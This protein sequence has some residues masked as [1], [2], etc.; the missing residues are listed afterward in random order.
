MVQVAR[1][2]SRE[3]A[4]FAARLARL[5]EGSD[6]NLSVIWRGRTVALCYAQGDGSIERYDS[7]AAL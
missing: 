5:R 6:D 1:A 4:G 7:L 3:A 2:P